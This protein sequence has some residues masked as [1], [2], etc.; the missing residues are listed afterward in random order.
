MFARDGQRAWLGEILHDEQRHRR[1]FV[2]F[3][4][5]YEGARR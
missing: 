5:E 1:L 2:G 3:E 4:R